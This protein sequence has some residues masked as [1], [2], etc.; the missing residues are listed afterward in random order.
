MKILHVNTSE[1]GGAAKAVI[2]LQEA[3]I[4]SNVDSKMLVLYKYHSNKEHIYSF[5]N[6]R[7]SLFQKL[8]YSLHYRWDNFFKSQKLR[9]KNRNYERFSFPNTIYDLTSHPLV[10]EADIIHLHW[11][12]G[13][14]DYHTFFKKINK[15]LVWTLHDL[16]PFNG[17]FHYK[18][19]YLENQIDFYKLDRDIRKIKQNALLKL[20]NLTVVNL[21]S[22]IYKLSTGSDILGR[23]KHKFIPNGLDM[24]VFKK[25]NRQSARRILNLP[26]NKKIILFIA[27]AINNKRKGFQYL[28]HALSLMP[29]EDLLLVVVGQGSTDSSPIP[30]QVLNFITDDHLLATVYSAADICVIPSIEDNLPNTVLESMACETPVIGF[31]VGGIP[32]MI[33]P[34]KT[35][36]LAKA[37]DEKDLAAKIKYL[38]E[39]E[40]FRR[41]LGK[42]ARLLAETEYNIHIQSAKYIELYEEILKTSP[43]KPTI[44]NKHLTDYWYT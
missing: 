26:E 34:N 44:F 5:Q 32:D 27:D 33:K 19:D 40:E 35:G 42:N 2:R 38:L 7:L 13:F 23:F 3:L 9:H 39:D 28:S 6:N 41:I 31:Q 29:H 4:Q 36:L 18:R 1:A 12:A 30:T 16:N 24:E 37:F 43:T 14:L 22:W 25:I 15:P 17:G 20:E 10:Q 8:K 11:V 21:S